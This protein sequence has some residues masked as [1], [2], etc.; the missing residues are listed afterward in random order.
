MT[1]EVL[2]Y[3]QQRYNLT[4][5]KYFSLSHLKNKFGQS[6][7]NDLNTLYKQGYIDKKDGANAP[8]I[9]LKP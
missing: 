3:L 2:T 5:W 1:N 4:G 6:V 9:E 8:V 7:T